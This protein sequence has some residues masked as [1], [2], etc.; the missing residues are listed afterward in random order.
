M[1]LKNCLVWVIKNALARLQYTH[2]KIRLQ[3]YTKYR[4]HGKK[5]EE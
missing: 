4:C 1:P 2:C 5:K 3:N